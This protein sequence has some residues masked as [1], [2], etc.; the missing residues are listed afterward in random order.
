MGTTIGDFNSD[1]RIDWYTT[2]IFDDDQVGRGDGN[3]LY[4]NQGGHNF[5]EVAHD[6]GVADGGW[7]WGTVAVDLNLDGLLDLVETNGW[8]D[9]D[10]YRDELSKVWIQNRDGSFQ[11]I[12]EESG[13][14]HR[15]D[16][17][18]LMHFDYDGDGDQDVV[19]TAPV[20]DLYLYRNDLTGS[21]T[22]WLRVILDTTSQPDLAPN[23]FGSTV[24]VRAGG[25]WQ[26]RY[27]TGCSNYLTQSDFNP[28]FG[29][30]SASTVD[31][32]RV[33]WPD[34]S[35]TVLEAVPADQSI[36]VSP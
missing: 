21:D 23:G 18:G 16:G 14:E 5:T 2:A 4:L 13:I 19:I 25:T 15:L 8:S 12:T 7:G 11:E 30:G 17:R 26:Y 22:H 33:T 3:K 36:V 29:L 34:G 1:G 6:V 24:A 10:S 9:L 20:D 28:H 31:E 35:E 27:V 32:V